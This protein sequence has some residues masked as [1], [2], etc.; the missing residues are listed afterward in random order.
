MSDKKPKKP[1]AWKNSFFWLG[2]ALLVLAV[3]GLFAGEGSIRDPGQVR[4]SGLVWMYLVG[5]VVMI[6]NGWLSHQQAVQH[7]VE[8]EEEV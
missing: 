3:V 2:A 6:V 1:V 5:G 8:E 7:F 4:E